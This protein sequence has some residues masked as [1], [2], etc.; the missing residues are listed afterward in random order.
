M[1]L[2]GLTGTHGAGK[3]TVSSYFVREYGFLCVSV[4]EFLAEEAERRGMKPDR[5]ARGDIANEYRAHGP[6]ALMEATYASIPVG[7]ERVILEP[8]YT[9]AEIAFVHEK[10]GVVISVD[11]DLRTRYDRVHVRGSAKDD[12]SFEQFVALEEL[13]S[14]DKDKQNVRAAMVAADI[15]LMNSGTLEELEAAVREALDERRI[16]IDVDTDVDTDVD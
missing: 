16:L 5:K 15:H 11:A 9:E 6:T 13:S 8:Q 2:I 12:V 1:Q 4:S 14:A 3:G 10:G 7:A